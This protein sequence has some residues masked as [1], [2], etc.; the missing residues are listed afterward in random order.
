ML[1]DQGSQAAEETGNSDQGTNP[2]AQESTVTATPELDEAGSELQQ[3]RNE[4]DKKN[5][6]AQRKITQMG[7]DNSQ[8]RDDLSQRDGEVQQLRQQVNELQ[9]KQSQYM[10]DYGLE[11]ANQE[12]SGS[13]GGR[14]DM[15]ERALGE[16]ITERYNMRES[17]AQADAGSKQTQRVQQYTDNYGMSAEDAQ[18]AIQYEDAGE[19]MNSHKVIELASA[20]NRSRQ[21]ANQR[22]GSYSST[23][24]SSSSSLFKSA[25]DN[26]AAV[27]NILGGSRTPEEVASLIADDP[28]LI[29][30]LGDSLKF[31]SE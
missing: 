11:D 18:L 22:R 19:F 3:M 23:E 31:S 7:Q 21:S 6:H 14:L 24:G 13:D 20:Q 12:A 26:K 15:M 9:S 30:K 28:S 4:M 27:D 16:T 29:D 17:L 10:S 25:T 8:M 2:V 1:E 5:V